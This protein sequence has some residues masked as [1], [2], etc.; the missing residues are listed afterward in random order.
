MN[1]GKLKTPKEVKAGEEVVLKE[2]DFVSTEGQ[3]IVQ[4]RKGFANVN[5]ETARRMAFRKKIV[6]KHAGSKKRK[7]KR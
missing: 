6:G 7:A 5:R 1:T 4:T 3:H 2:S